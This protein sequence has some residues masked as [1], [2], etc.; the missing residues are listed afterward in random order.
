MVDQSPAVGRGPAFL[1]GREATRELKAALDRDE[2]RG[3]GRLTQ[4]RFAELIGTPPI[5][6][7]YNGQLVRQIKGL[8]CGQELLNQQERL[9]LHN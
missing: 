3:G 4:K 7:E 9:G 5:N 1:S 8:L 2:S 6:N